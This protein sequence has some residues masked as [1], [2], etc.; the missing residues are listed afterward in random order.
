MELVGRP[1]HEIAE[2]HGIQTPADLRHNKGWIGQLL[3]YVLGATAGSKAK[4]DFPH[5]GI[6]MK[7]IPTDSRGRPRE[8]TYVCVAPLDGSMA[9][10]WQ[11]SWVRAKLSS[12][13]WL[14]IITDPGSS[15]GQRI[16]GPIW[17]WQPG[18]SEE[19][20]LQADWETLA[21]LIALGEMWQLDAHKGDVL[22]IRPKGANSN[23]FTWVLDEEGQWIKTM[24]RGFYLRSRFTRGLLEPHF[25]KWNQAAPTDASR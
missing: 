21:E 19:A 20:Q 17:L 11:Q 22:Q 23:D 25:A 7:T 18:P 4:P 16:V 12:V 14:P 15:V 6:E 2:S 5:L 3:E 13:L 8:S 9:S 24:S 10:S 1:L